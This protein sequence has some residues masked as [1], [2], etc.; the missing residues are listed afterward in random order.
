MTTSRKE[1]DFEDLEFGGM[2]I[3]LILSVTD[4]VLY[5]RR[6]GHNILTLRFNN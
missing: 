1:K 2:G 4:D 5:E 6:G 3:G